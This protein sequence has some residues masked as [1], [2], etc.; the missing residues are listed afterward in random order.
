MRKLFNG[1]YHFQF[2]FLVTKLP[3]TFFSSLRLWIQLILIL[4]S[5]NYSLAGKSDHLVS[6]NLPVREHNSPVAYRARVFTVT[7]SSVVPTAVTTQL[8]PHEAERKFIWVTHDLHIWWEI[9][10]DKRFLCLNPNSNPYEGSK[11]KLVYLTSECSHFPIYKIHFIVLSQE[12]ILVIGEEVD[13][14]LSWPCSF[15]ACTTPWFHSP[16]TYKSKHCVVSTQPQQSRGRG[17]KSLTFK[18]TLSHV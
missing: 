7:S 9:F 15:T 11:A 2:F 10:L 12:L 5:P 1:T 16:A 6:G 18:I 3:F 4:L 8:E 17:R 13:M 14:K